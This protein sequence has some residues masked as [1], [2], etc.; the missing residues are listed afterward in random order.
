MRKH[1]KEK[2]PL[3]VTTNPEIRR[4][5]A[6][7]NGLD[8]RIKDVVQELRDIINQMN[9]LVDLLILKDIIGEAFV[10]ETEV[11]YPDA[12]AKAK[13]LKF[14]EGYAPKTAK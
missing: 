7:E 11:E 9:S 13:L 10:I 6:L 14:L 4:E 8:D 5:E 1:I 12:A 2:L 3:L